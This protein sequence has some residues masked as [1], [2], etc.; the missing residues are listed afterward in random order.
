MHLRSLHRAPALPLI[1]FLSHSHSLFTS[2]SHE[3]HSFHTTWT[4]PLHFL[5]CSLAFPALTIGPLPSPLLSLP[6]LRIRFAA[7]PVHLRCTSPYVRSPHCPYISPTSAWGSC[8]SR[9]HLTPALLF[10]YLPLGGNCSTFPPYTAT[11]LSTFAT[12][13]SSSGF[14]LSYG[15][16]RCHTRFGFPSSS[17][18]CL[19]APFFWPPCPPSCPFDSVPLRLSP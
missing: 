12:S 19:R 14:L 8:F 15:P 6:R 16:A 13:S 2:S 7:R 18:T 5:A 1:I 10:L 11:P 3:R 9:C 17:R 4:A